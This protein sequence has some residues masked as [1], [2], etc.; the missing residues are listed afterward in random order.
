MKMSRNEEKQ[1]EM[2]KTMSRRKAAYD[3]PRG[4][5]DIFK[6]VVEIETKRAR[7]PRIDGSRREGGKTGG[8]GGWGWNGGGREGGW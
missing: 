6:D 3:N 4:E 5:D 7:G 2:V 8:G 1:K